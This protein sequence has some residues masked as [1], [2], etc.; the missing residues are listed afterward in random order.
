MKKWPIAIQV[1]TVDKEATA[2]F[3]GTARA[4]KAMGYDGVELCDTYG[5]TAVQLRKICDEVGLAVVGAHVNLNEIEDDA[6][7]ADYVAAGVKYI[8][9][10]HLKAPKTEEELVATIARIRAACPQDFSVWS[11]NDDQTVPVMSL[12]GQGVIS[13]LSNVC[14]VE[15]LTM[16]QAALA[17]DFDTAAALQCE[18]LPLIELLFCEVNP[19]P[20]KA[21]LNLM[22]MEAGTLRMP[23]TDMEPANV[24][25]LEKAMKEYGIL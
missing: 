19:I 7:L 5:G 20:V 18:L 24:A 10:P 16:T 22:G 21:A 11:G 1:Y 25:R 3:E 2:D 15:T 13:V 9:I 17:G 23:L 12:G 14:P 8:V 6:I 4:L